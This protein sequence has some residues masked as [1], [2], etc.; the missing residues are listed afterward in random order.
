MYKNFGL[1]VF[2]FSRWLPHMEH[3]NIYYGDR[4]LH[5]ITQYTA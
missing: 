1:N 5:V 3:N 2:Q 4:T